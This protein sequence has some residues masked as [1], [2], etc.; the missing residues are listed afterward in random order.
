MHLPPGQR[1]G[2]YEIVAPIGAGGMGEVYR[3]R[4]TRIDRTVAIKVLP[5]E[6][7]NDANLKLRFEREA[8]SIS[9]LNH[10]HICTLHDLGRENGIDYLVM[11][12]CEGKT[13]ATRIAE[14]ALPLGQVF[15]YGIQIADALHKAHRQGII[16]RDLKPSN[17]MLTK[18]GVKL[19]DFGLAKQHGEASPE[20]A[21]ARQMTEE[22]RILGTVQYMAPEVL[23]GKEADARSDIFAIGLVLY[24]MI[25]GKP[26]F[27]GSSK[28]SLIAAILEHEPKPIAELK[29]ASPPALDRLIRACL[30]KDP[31]ERIQT[32]HDATLQLKWI[33]EGVAS[34]APPSPLKRFRGWPSIV[35]AASVLLVVTAA[36]VVAALLFPRS[37]SAIRD[38]PS[39]RFEV[40]AT[41]KH[42]RDA[43]GLRV[44]PDGKHFV[45]PAIGEDGVRRLFMRGPDD[46]E[47]KPIAGTDGLVF[48]KLPRFLF[49]PNGQTLYFPVENNIKAL[50]LSSGSLLD[51]GQIDNEGDGWTV[52]AERMFLYE[53]GLT[54]QSIVLPGGKAVAVTKL[55]K[56]RDEVRHQWP[57]FLPDG[58]QFLF[59]ARSRAKSGE[60]TS[61]IY[62]GTVGSEKRTPLL[63]ASSRVDYVLPGYL[64]FA[65]GNTLH[66]VPFDLKSSRITGAEVPL[67]DDLNA[68]AET[69][70]AAFSVSGTVLTY[71]QR[72]DRARLAWFDRSG[73]ELPG[74]K[75]AG[76]FWA[77]AL[78]PDGNRVAASVL[79]EATG[80]VDIWV[81]GLDRE[82]T[83]RLTFDPGRQDGPVWIDGGRQIVYLHYTDEQNTEIRVMSADDPGAPRILVGGD[84]VRFPSQTSPSGDMLLYTERRDKRWEIWQ[85][86]LQGE[87]RPVPLV[88]APFNVWGGSVSPS[89]KWLL[90]VSDES[91]RREIYA[92]P[93][94]RSGSRIQVTTAG[95]AW[96]IWSRD[97]KEILLGQGAAFF[98][99]PVTERGE[100]LDFGEPRHLFSRADWQL[101]G[102]HPDGRLL[103]ELPVDDRNPPSIVITNWPALMKAKSGS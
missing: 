1:L 74:L 93:Y 55:D 39:F 6:F 66:V 3:G 78:S 22:G 80:T 57:W 56:A 79:S 76:S 9:A 50:R 34:A 91:G 77:S 98:S 44:S 23:V 11:E 47:M 95:A 72:L 102:Q 94:R 82:T 81:Y 40:P 4:D 45:G 62:L 28:A 88:R 103:L 33:A 97:G 12:Y 25:T 84:G 64:L 60:E 54:I 42:Y 61:T 5:A 86:P 38:T 26:A 13:L 67:I 7:A 31:D 43:G 27:S 36:I 101:S 83:S 10:P 30:A 48:T 58:K 100:R 92:R 73:K 49:S 70:W 8:K 75:R 52:N 35:A 20:A 17:I 69:G 19:L 41:A 99:V 16:H 65:R 71:R 32:A 46:A 51:L 68:F 2:P 15:D 85:V 59:L 89:G 21:T 29:P 63:N 24:E 37:R 90:Y 14:G 87:P 18:S 96:G 53:G